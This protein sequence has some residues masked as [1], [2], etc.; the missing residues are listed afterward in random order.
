M[1]RF[2]SRLFQR[3]IEPNEKYYWKFVQAELL[4][5]IAELEES[6]CSCFTCQSELEKFKA[7]LDK[8]KNKAPVG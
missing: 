5:R 7:Y 8:L 3:Y 6:K 1:K 2:H 4:Y